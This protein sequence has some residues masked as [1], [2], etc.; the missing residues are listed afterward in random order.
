MGRPEEFLLVDGYNIVNSWPQLRE[1]S[2]ECLEESR[3]LLIDILQDYQG[4]V[5]INVIVVF[6]AHLLVGGIERHEYFGEIE[7]VYT[8]EGETADQYI[9][10]WVNDMGK[11]HRI[12]VASSDFVEQTIILSRGGTRISARELYMEVE[13]V[14]Q[15]RNEKHIYKK[16]LDSNHLSDNLS[17][18]VFEVLE[19]M[20]RQT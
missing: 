3:D 2:K 12:R 11:D 5:G 4:Y 1:I 9:E 18:E 7:V 10:R 20:R 16:K 8:K 6:D 15:R 19:R 14:A 17:P 13:M